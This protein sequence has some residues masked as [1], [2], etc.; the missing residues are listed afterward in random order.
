MRRAFLSTGSREESGSFFQNTHSTK[1]QMRRLRLW[2]PQAARVGSMRA[3]TSEMR[4]AGKPPLDACS[5]MS[6][7][8]G[9]V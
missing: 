5:R 2:F 8:L 1:T 4:L 9:A 6:V 3:L 7:S